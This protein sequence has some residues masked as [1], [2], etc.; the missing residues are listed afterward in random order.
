[1]GGIWLV[2]SGLLVR[3]PRLAWLLRL[4]SMAP[5]VLL[6]ALWYP[7]FMESRSIFKTGADW[8]TM[9]W[10]RLS[11]VRFCENLMGGQG[12]PWPAATGAA[13]ALWLLTVVIT[14][15]GSL[16]QQ[17]DRLLLVMA[18]VFGAIVLF[19]PA[20]YT[21]TI[22]F[23][24]R[25]APCAVA[26]LLVGLPE[27]RFP[28]HLEIFGLLLGAACA[29]TSLAWR[30]FST[31]EMSGFQEA[32]D[33]TPANARILE[34]DSVHESR[35]VGGRPFMQMM[36]Y[37]QAEKGGM[38]NFSFAEHGSSLVSYR[39]PR[40]LTWSP[41]LEWHPERVRKEDVLQFDVVLLNG[42][43]ETHQWFPSAAPVTAK[44]TTGRW[45]LY[46][47]RRVQP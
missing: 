31:E 3:P 37:L 38:L 12:G 30:S 23:A 13:L 25:W 24:Q 7:K 44:T 34:L 32:L 16:R 47:V 45:R 33:A 1:M 20:K 40:E 11:P 18:A 35:F 17:S 5:G 29:T 14:R 46:A 9:P 43:P 39:Q 8:M 22:F 2:L 21:N 6:A 41:G 36:G 15:W 4:S 10:E 19:A 42:K 28:R 27:P 26:L